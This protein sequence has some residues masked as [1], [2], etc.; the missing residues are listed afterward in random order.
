VWKPRRSFGGVGIER[1]EDL[2]Q[3]EALMSG[4]E[5][6]IVQEWIEGQDVSATALADS[7]R[8]LAV[9]TYRVLR[10]HPARYGPAVAAATVADEAL[11]RQV[12]HLLASTEYSGVANL[13]W[14]R[15]KAT[16]KLYLVDFNARFGGT[17]E[18]ALAAGV[19]IVSMLYDVAVGD[20]STLRPR[21]RPGVE[22]SWA[23]FGEMHQLVELRSVRD[24]VT[25]ATGL[26]RVQT[27]G[28]WRDPL[29]HGVQVLSGA[30][31]RWQ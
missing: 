24:A 1:V 28:S 9:A 20:T 5:E 23:F 10:Q 7:G 18:I 26:H 19:D 4:A 15:E 12:E 17:T 22:F 3:L 29:P 13:D 25:W 30:L 21:M 6:A 14:R 2:Q 11:E 27:N 8:T 16:G 31:R